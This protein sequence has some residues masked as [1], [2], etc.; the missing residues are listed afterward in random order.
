MRNTERQ[1]LNLPI[2]PLSQQF[3]PVY[4][5]AAHLAFARDEIIE[6]AVQYGCGEKAKALLP[7]TIGG[8]PWYMYVDPAID[9]E[10]LKLTL[11]CLRDDCKFIAAFME[12][13]QNPK[14][15]QEQPAT[16]TQRSEQ[17]EISVSDEHDKK[18]DKHSQE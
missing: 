10:E 8:H 15:E 5:A 7:E 9:P 3:H 11:D 1:I 16:K 4:V 13:E 12:G 18:I 17:I 2:F 6:Q 14:V